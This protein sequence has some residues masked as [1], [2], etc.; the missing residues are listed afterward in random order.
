MRGLQWEPRRETSCWKK[1]ALSRRPFFLESLQEAGQH[2]SGWTSLQFKTSKSVQCFQS[3]SNNPLAPIY[4][5]LLLTLTL[6]FSSHYPTYDRFKNVKKWDAIE[7]HSGDDVTGN[8][9]WKHLVQFTSHT[10]LCDSLQLLCHQ[11]CALSAAL[12]DELGDA[13]KDDSNFFFAHLVG[14]LWKFWQER[15]MEIKSNK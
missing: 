11:W 1:T 3:S 8:N 14:R 15:N 2:L 10:W 13:D 7:V 9:F 4:Y 5:L 12:K 6:L